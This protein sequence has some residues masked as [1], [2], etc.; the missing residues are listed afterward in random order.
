[1][2]STVSDRLI[3][4]LFPLTLSVAPG[5]AVPLHIF[6]EQYKQMVSW[7]LEEPRTR[8]IGISFIV[9]AGKMHTLCKIGTAVVIEKILNRYEDGTYD[10]LVRG[11]GRFELHEILERKPYYEG[12]VSTVLDEKKADKTSKLAQHVANLLIAVFSKRNEVIPHINPTEYST[13]SFVAAGLG[14]FSNEEK[15]SLIEN[16]SEEARLNFIEKKLSRLLFV[17]DDTPNSSSHLP[18]DDY[19]Q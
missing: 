11:V 9:P 18:S 7:C 12:V 1:M 8:P 3:I 10:I 2:V 13:F 14:H 4:P 6:E 15:Q 19:L 17:E 5:E 16:T